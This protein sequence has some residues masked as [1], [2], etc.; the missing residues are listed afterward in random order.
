M[1][2]YVTQITSCMPLY[3]S[4][5]V[6]LAPDR[7]LEPGLLSAMVAGQVIILALSQIP[8][9]RLMNRFSTAR[10]LILSCAIWFLGFVLA[11]VM[12]LVSSNQIIVAMAALLAMSIATAAYAP[13]SSALIVDLAPPESLAIYFSINSLCWAL[14]AMLGPP[15]VLSSMEHFHKH[16]PYIWLVVAA[17]TIFPAILFQFLSRHTARQTALTA[18]NRTEP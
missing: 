16:S 2:A 3:M 6:R 11:A 9:T 8:V 15:L 1:T 4:D 14:G 17:T 12:G 13:P 7:P 10:S 18:Q 5:R